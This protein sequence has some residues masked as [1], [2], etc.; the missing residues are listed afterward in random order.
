MGAHLFLDVAMAHQDPCGAAQQGGRG[1]AGCAEQREHDRERWKLLQLARS[2]AG[3]EVADEPRPRAF[4]GF[5][6]V[7]QDV[8]R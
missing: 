7:F 6:E 8:P 1:F 3:G 5:L 2:V 4:T